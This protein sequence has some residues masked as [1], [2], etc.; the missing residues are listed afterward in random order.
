LS[1]QKQNQIKKVQF[2][3]YEFLGKKEMITKEI[4]INAIV[5]IP[6][7]YQKGFF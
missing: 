7:N 4:P 5:N 3:F 6:T 2:E 1:K